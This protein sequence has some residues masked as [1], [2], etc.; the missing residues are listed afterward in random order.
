M[1][2]LGLLNQVL[3]DFG[4]LVKYFLAVTFVL[5]G[6]WYL[7]LFSVF[8]LYLCLLFCLI[9]VLCGLW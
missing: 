6:F 8:V 7:T 1:W 4:V 9:L 2:F 3:S 5:C